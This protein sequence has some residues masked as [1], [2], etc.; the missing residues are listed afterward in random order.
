MTTPDVDGT[1]ALRRTCA[2]VSSSQS[3]AL[4]W[5]PRRTT[6]G[7]R[8]TSSTAT[9]CRS[10]PWA[11]R[12]RLDRQRAG[13]QHPA[14]LPGHRARRGRQRERRR[15]TRWPGPWPTRHAPTAPTRLT[16]S[17]S[18]FTVRLTWTAATD[19]VG[20]VRYT[21][22]RGGVAIGTSTATAYTD[23]AQRHSA[24][25]SSY[26]VRARDA[27]GNV[28]AASN[29]V[30]VTVPAD[31]QSDTPTAPADLSGHGRDPADHA[32]LERIH[33][34]RRGDQLLPLPR[35]LEVPPAR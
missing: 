16:G 11:V 12:R 19:N 8:T 9:A 29:T 20:V 22:Y 32:D 33:R 31:T 25:T 27:A 18:G 1:D 21:I 26:T 4:T 10:P 7:W 6:S 35:Q 28:G 5:N 34:Q 17:L 3:V 30:S 14:P 13:R 15:A 23:I 2:A 24:R